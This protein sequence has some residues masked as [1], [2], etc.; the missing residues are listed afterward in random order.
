[1]SLVGSGPTVLQE[2]RENC[3]KKEA[4]DCLKRRNVWEKLPESVKKTL[5]K[6]NKG[7]VHE[8]NGDE[9]HKSRG[10][11]K[12]KIFI[13][14]SVILLLALFTLQY[15]QVPSKSKTSLLLTTLF[16]SSPSKPD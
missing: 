8:V 13:I 2:D 1:M 11:G 6:N 16:F 4:I 7:E 10:L 5:G 12:K 14:R 3:Q 15:F 9:R